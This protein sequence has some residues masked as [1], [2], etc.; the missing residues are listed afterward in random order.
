[1]NWYKVFYWISVADKVQDFVL[2][3]AIA[4]SIILLVAFVSNI[5]ARS[6]YNDNMQDRKANDN[7]YDDLRNVRYMKMFK[8]YMIWSSILFAIFWLLYI[9]T[10]SKDDAVLIIA[11]GAVGNFITSDSSS[12]QLPADLT[13]FLRARIHQ[14]TDEAKENIG[15]EDDRTRKI[16]DLKNLDKDEIIK[17]LKQ[18]TT[19]IK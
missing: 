5:V 7:D 13:A 15:I 16:N 3:I 17:R 12:K 10:P 1:M 2:T 11:G 9:A 8:Q 19:L 6:S 14:M 18:D 4:S